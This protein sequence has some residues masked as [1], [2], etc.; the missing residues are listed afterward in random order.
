M[1][2]AHDLSAWALGLGLARATAVISVPKADS[3]YIQGFARL[4]SIFITD[5]VQ[6]P[7]HHNHSHVLVTT[8]N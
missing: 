7:K 1:I 5:T 2:S 4:Q 8:S 6:V 3:H